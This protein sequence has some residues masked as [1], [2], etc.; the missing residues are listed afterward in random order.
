MLLGAGVPLAAVAAGS[1]WLVERANAASGRT[2]AITRWAGSQLAFAASGSVA[3]L[4]QATGRLWHLRRRSWTSPPTATGFAAT[5]LVPSWTGQT[6]PGTAVRVWLRA[7]STT[8]AWSRWFEM[9]LWTDDGFGERS[10]PSPTRGSQ[11][12][13]RDAVA[14]TA[15][16]TL[17]ATAGTSFQAWQLRLEL[18]HR[19]H[20]TARPSLR[21]AAVVASTTPASSTSASPSGVARGVELAVPAYSQMLHEG[22]YPDFDGGGEAWCSAT[23]TAMVLDFWGKGPTTAESG[24]V[25]P[26][27]HTN[28]QVD[29][30]ARSVW[31]EQ[32]GG[33]G[34]WSFNVAHAG[35]RGLDGFVTRLR[36]LAEAEL[37]I[38]A[39]IPLVVSTSFT[40]AQL[41]GA[42][43]GTNGHLMLIRGF[44]GNGRVIVNDPASGL[45]ASN[46]QVR[47]VYDRAQFESAWGRSG[48]TTY[49]VFP[50]GRSLPSRSTSASGGLP[51]AW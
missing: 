27:P 41:T 47:R 20:S 40:S 49:V 37:F 10:C 3:H 15:T 23:C 24:W 26:R 43:F 42:G 13:T 25:A 1:P 11:P 46:A 36:S 14:R 18:L 38:A 45:Q 21:Q 2:S 51:A 30:V 7:Q 32:F 4:D 39:G 29:H 19:A 44:D 28:P 8:G 33:T 16:D 34:N 12:T 50:P 35:E 22:H 6:P 48:G 17:V 31:D 5:Q 9:A